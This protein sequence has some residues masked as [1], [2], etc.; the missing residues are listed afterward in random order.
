MSIIGKFQPNQH[1]LLITGDDANNNLTVSRDLDGHLFENGNA[2]DGDPT[3]ANT[4]L[5][6][7]NAGDGNDVITLD[8]TNGPLPAA[9][10]F[11]GGGN[12]TLTGGS[13]NDRLSGQGGSDNLFGQGG[14]DTLDG[15]AGSDFIAGGAGNDTLIGGAGN[16]FL[17]G[18]QGIDI[19]YLGAGNDVFRW[20]PGDGSD[21]VEGGSGF[22]E[23]LFN[24]AAGAEQFALTA[25]D[26]RSSFTRVQ[27]SIVMDMND[28]EKVTVNALGGADT[29]TINDPSGTDITDIAINLGVGGVG[30][31]AADTIF[32]NDDDDVTVV[33]NG[34]GNLTIFGVSGATVH[35][36][37]FEEANDHLIIDGQPFLF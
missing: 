6:R 18:D 35:I 17:D 32:I 22:D 15:G 8:E 27:G 7:V 30:D 12:D 16:D 28:V 31:G 5:I 19:G 13:G 21:I 9:Q 33:D 29:I 4:N 34:N 37:G 36:T 14:N 20:D 1:R 10:L 24:G 2:I 25:N 11:G 26:E 3:V 23:M